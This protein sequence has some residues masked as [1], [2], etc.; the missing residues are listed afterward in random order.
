MPAG[1]SAVSLPST[2]A[3][4][5][6]PPADAPIA[7][8]GAAPPLTGATTRGLDAVGFSSRRPIWSILVSSGWLPS[9]SVPLVNVGVSTAS[10]APAPI[11]SYTRHALAPTLLVTTRIAHGWLDAMMR[12]V[13]STPS[14]R[15]MIKSISTTS[16]GCAA[17]KST[18][19]APS[20]ATHSTR[21][22]GRRAI[23]RRM[24]STASGISLTMPMFMS[25]PLQSGLAPHRAMLHRGNCPWR[26]SN[27][28]RLPARGGD[29]PPD[30]CRTRPSPAVT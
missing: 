14:K 18:A 13:A 27:R 17:Q 22:S 16:G 11:A 6:G 9:A 7:T 25:A 15:G 20:V 1:N 29:P 26:G 12:R 8:K 28:R 10:S 23:V 24:A 19:C 3:S 2:V 30:P 5:V 21:C 4:A